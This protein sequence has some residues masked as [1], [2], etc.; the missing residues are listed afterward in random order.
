MPQLSQE[1]LASVLASGYRRSHRVSPPLDG[2]FTRRSNFTVRSPLRPHHDLVAHGV[3]DFELPRAHAHR[4]H[5]LYLH[6]H[7]I[8]GRVWI[9]VSRASRAPTQTRLHP[10]ARARSDHI[11]LRGFSIV[12]DDGQPVHL[13]TL[14]RSTAKRN[15]VGVRLGSLS[16]RRGLVDVDILL[17]LLALVLSSSA[18]RRGDALDRKT[19]E[20]RAH[21]RG[22]RRSIPR[23]V[24]DDE[25]RARPPKLHPQ[26]L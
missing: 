25:S 13:D 19:L 9:R 4:Y 18:R 11:A 21:P 12:D 24:R 23:T 1:S 10:H 14:R 26:S 17:V 3:D 5:I 8:L 7:H 2:S 15:F 22:R 6:V 16:R 20:T